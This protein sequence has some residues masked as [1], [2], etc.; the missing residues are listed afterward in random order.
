GSF[1]PFINLFFADRF[2]L[3]FRAIGIALGT[4]AVAGSV[5]ALIHGRFIARRVGAV[6][7][8]ATVVLSSLPFALVA[9]LTGN[10]AVAVIALAV[11]AMLMFGTQATW[12]AYQLS[13]FTPAERA[14]ATGTVA[15]GWNLA[16]AIAAC[17]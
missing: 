10:V 6:S 9:A 13:S 15:L 4:I 11:R 12:S 3:E 5:G 16:A 1:I 17:G 7:A 2:A 8:V 14:A